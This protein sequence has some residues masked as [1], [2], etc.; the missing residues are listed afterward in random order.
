METMTIAGRY[1][2]QISSGA[3]KVET[4]ISPYARTTNEQSLFI[5]IAKPQQDRFVKLACVR[6]LDGNADCLDLVFEKSGIVR[7][8]SW[9]A[10]T[11]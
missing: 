10:E 4:L 9:S 11:S 5:Q 2:R 3:S 1:Y 6:P 7:L 8:V